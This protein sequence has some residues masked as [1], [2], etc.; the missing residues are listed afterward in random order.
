MKT[1]RKNN[2][3]LKRKFSKRRKTTKRR[4]N[5]KTNN[6]KYQKRIKRKTSRRTKRKLKR[7]VKR[8][9]IQKGGG[10]TGNIKEMLTICS[11]SRFAKWLG[12]ISRIRGVIGAI[13]TVRT[14]RARARGA[15]DQP[16]ELNISFVRHG[17]SESNELP[18]QLEPINAWRH[19]FLTMFGRQQAYAFGYDT[20][21]EKWSFEGSRKRVTFSCSCLPRACE[22]AKLI[23]QGFMDRLTE[24][25]VGSTTLE[26]LQKEKIKLINGISEIPEKKFKVYGE[27]LRGTQR[28]ITGDMLNSVV[29]IL[30]QMDKGLLL[31]ATEEGYAVVENIK[32]NQLVGFDGVDDYVDLRRKI[33]FWRDRFP[34]QV[35]TFQQQLQ[36]IEYITTEESFNSFANRIPEIFEGC[37]DAI[38]V[39]VVHGK[40][41]QQKMVSGLT[42]S[43]FPVENG[44]IPLQEPEPDTADKPENDSNYSDGMLFMGGGMKGGGDDRLTVLSPDIRRCNIVIDE[45]HLYVQGS[46]KSSLQLGISDLRAGALVELKPNVTWDR[47]KKL[48]SQLV[49]LNLMEVYEIN[50]KGDYIPES[51]SE[52]TEEQKEEQPLPATA[53]PAPPPAAAPAPAAPAAPPPAPAAAAPALEESE[54]T[55]EQKQKQKWADDQGGWFPELLEKYPVKF[56]TLWEALSNLYASGESGSSD[57]AIYNNYREA[58]G[59][60]RDAIQENNTKKG[61]RHVKNF[62]IF[63]TTYINPLLS[64][65][66]I[67]E[68]NLDQGLYNR[69]IEKQAGARQGA[70]RGGANTGDEN[71]LFKFVFSLDGKSVEEL[72]ELNALYASC[73]LTNISIQLNGNLILLSLL[74]DSSANNPFRGSSNQ[75]P[76]ETWYISGDGVKIQ[77]E[78]ITYQSLS[79][80]AP[81]TRLGWDEYQTNK[82]RTLNKINS[83]VKSFS[84]NDMIR[85]KNLFLLIQFLGSKA[86][87]LSAIISDEQAKKYFDIIQKMY[88]YAYLKHAPDNTDDETVKSIMR[89]ESN[90]A[91]RLYPPNLCACDFTFAMDEAAR[92]YY[93]SAFDGSYMISVP[94]DVKSSYPKAFGDE[95]KQKWE[96]LKMFVLKKATYYTP[97]LMALRFPVE[98][99]YKHTIDPGILLLIE[100]IKKDKTYKTGQDPRLAGI[101]PYRN[102]MISSIM[103]ETTMRALNVDMKDPQQVLNY[104]APPPYWGS[105][106]IDF[107]KEKQRVMKFLNV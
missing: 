18:W 1:V 7:S 19:P 93:R 91:F 101:D 22:T 13:S 10:A 73:W 86:V 12:G 33:E 80:S 92:N 30:N 106:R 63:V 2:R 103:D 79:K 39:C 46:D 71:K 36:D 74:I 5:K 58:R 95:K 14:R 75:N 16:A 52:Q 82:Q 44:L 47:H 15:R 48:I 25:Q 3:N 64:E 17:I 51:E 54:Q 68:G 41:I 45:L 94:T 84:E 99:T 28:S 4:M 90:S 61:R 98:K 11:K 67:S 96:I 97:T 55:E 27:L 65:I 69:K 62:D 72:N 26:E 32:P 31:A 59:L 29:Q 24:S 40:F 9:D 49:G 56:N 102:Q 105:G 77:G 83:L 76:G 6:K 107:E 89:G 81:L 100:S 37:E 43:A 53:E 8:Y 88:M 34:E 60:Y 78:E 23:S 85:I 70:W 57:L 42:L 21:Y 35:A 38:N 66:S 87:E 104:L 20:L 50:D